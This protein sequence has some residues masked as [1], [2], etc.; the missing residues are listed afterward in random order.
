[1]QITNPLTRLENL[2]LSMYKTLFYCEIKIDAKR[3]RD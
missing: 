1:M 2:L 3:K